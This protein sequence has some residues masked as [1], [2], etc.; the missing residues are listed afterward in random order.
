MLQDP[1]DTGPD[2]R[3]QPDNNLREISIDNNSEHTM[4]IGADLDPQEAAS[5]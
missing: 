2:C 5:L 1:V 4:R 3:P